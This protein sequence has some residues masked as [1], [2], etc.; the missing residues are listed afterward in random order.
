MIPQYDSRGNLEAIL[1]VF[2]GTPGSQHDGHYRPCVA[3]YNR[4]WEK[5]FVTVLGKYH[6]EEK[7][8]YFSYKG[9]EKDTDVNI[10]ETYEK[11]L[12]TLSSKPRPGWAIENY[13][14]KEYYWAICESPK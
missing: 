11:E 6:V 7:V 4:F 1:P 5:D 10:G 9:S 13:D 3:R 14:G 12:F 8:C 2:K